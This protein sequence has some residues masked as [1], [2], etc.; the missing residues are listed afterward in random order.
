MAH[1]LVV[2]LY[3]VFYGLKNLWESLVS[4][5]EKH[6]PLLL[7]LSTLWLAL[8]IDLKYDEI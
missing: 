6:D 1:I 3:G 7:S 2:Y 8:S 4:R 5:G